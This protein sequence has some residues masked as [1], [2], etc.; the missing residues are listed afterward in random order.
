MTC[1]KSNKYRGYSQKNLWLKRNVGDGVDA[2]SASLCQGP[3]RGGHPVEK[4][5]IGVDLAKHVFPV[6]GLARMDR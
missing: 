4:V 2:P 6:H 3:L 5:M 1:R